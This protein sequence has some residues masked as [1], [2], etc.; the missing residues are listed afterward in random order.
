MK[1]LKESR[2][3]QTG[4]EVKEDLAK[5]YR[6]LVGLDETAEL[7]ED[8]INQDVVRKMSLKKNEPYTDVKKKILGEDVTVDQA[9]RD[10]EAEEVVEAED[11]EITEALNDSL[12]TARRKQRAGATNDFP[13]ILLVSEPGFAKTSV[14]KQWAKENGVNLVY[15]DAKSVNASDFS[16]PRLDPDDSRYTSMVGSKVFH[17]LDK[18]NSVLFLDEF[19]RAR[20]DVRGT[21]LTLIQD[22]TVWDPSAE[23]GQRFLSNFLFTV[24]AINPPS[25]KNKNA[26]RLEPAEMGRFETVAITGNPRQHLSYLTKVYT[27]EA[28]S[29]EDEA[30][31]Q[32]SLGRLELAK[33][34]LTHKLFKYD[35]SADI[36]DMSD[37]EAP[38]SYRTVKLALD[39][40]DGTKNSFLKK[41]RRF[42]NDKAAN[43]AEQIL[44]NYVDI[45]DKATQA[46][47]D[48]EAEED[49]DGVFGSDSSWDKLKRSLAGVD[50][51]SFSP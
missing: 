16:L 29:A 14:V 21:L 39:G 32:E 44:A 8:M 23:D 27:E 9:A 40:S 47:K 11:D 51:D 48:A 1:I 5:E 37:S 22:H 15:F 34:L 18:P 24:A 49:E 30:E 6:E 43:T 28:N 45:Q 19:N 42:T 33:A 3:L 25:Y 46:L 38:V 36:E 2:K 31:K 20:A 41:Y 7:T 13:N 4:A 26:Q 10:V 35:S 50:L 17:V 12:R